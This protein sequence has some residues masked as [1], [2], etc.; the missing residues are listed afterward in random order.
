MLSMSTLEEGFRLIL[1]A[2]ATIQ[3]LKEQRLW[4]RSDPLN[5]IALT[6]DTLL[7]AKLQFKKRKA[8]I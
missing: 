5:F 4:D 1:F 2:I 3:L 7:V 8:L 6:L